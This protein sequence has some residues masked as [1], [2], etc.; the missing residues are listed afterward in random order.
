MQ[1]SITYHIQTLPSLHSVEDIHQVQT[2]IQA[3]NLDAWVLVTERMLL[4]FHLQFVKPQRQK[5]QTALYLPADSIPGGKKFTSLGYRKIMNKYIYL[6]M[7]PT[8]DDK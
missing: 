2:S 6:E 4:L 8:A 5:E 7:S 3:I 1:T